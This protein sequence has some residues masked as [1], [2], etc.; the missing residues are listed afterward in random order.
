MKIMFSSGEYDDYS[1][2][3]Y[4]EVPGLNWVRDKLQQWLESNPNDRNM[5]C[6]REGA[7]VEWLSHQEECKQIDN[8]FT[9]CY[10]G[11]YSVKEV[12]KAIRPR[13]TW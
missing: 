9:E 11:A 4:F 2:L 6:F 5:Y 13:T 8:G 10:L 3:G 12:D 7:F 1:V